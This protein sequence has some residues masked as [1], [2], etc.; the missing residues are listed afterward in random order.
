MVNRIIREDPSKSYM[1]N[2]QGI[3]PK[4]LWMSIKDYDLWPLYIIGLSFTIPAMPPAMYLTLSLRK[5]GFDT[6]QTNL[7]A[8]PHSAFHSKHT[9]S[10]CARILRV[11]LT[12]LQ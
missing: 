10:G 7:L 2:R 3:T 9:Q 5:L 12:E 1:H 8:I 6:F 4:L 11:E